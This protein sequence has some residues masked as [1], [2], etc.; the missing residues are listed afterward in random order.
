MK[1]LILLVFTFSIFCSSCS[2]DDDNGVPQQEYKILEVND[3][4]VS[5]YAFFVGSS[6]SDEVFNI[7]I[8]LI[9]VDIDVPYTAYL[10]SNSLSEGGEIV[11][12]LDDFLNLHEAEVMS[13]WTSFHSSNQIVI[14]NEVFDYQDLIAF[15]GHIKIFNSN[16]LSTPIAQCNIGSN[17]Q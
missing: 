17:A 1:K 8:Q 5:G 9:D 2:N 11:T 3:S 7:A 16:D 4:G 13:S 10:Y 12:E 6:V 14:E 15:D